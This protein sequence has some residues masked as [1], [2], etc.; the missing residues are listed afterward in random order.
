[1]LAA[2]PHR[3]QEMSETQKAHQGQFRQ[4]IGYSKGARETQEY[5]E[6]AASRGLR[7]ITSPWLTS[8]IRQSEVVE[9]VADAADVAAHVADEVETAQVV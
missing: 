1:M 9:I 3:S 7:R 4:A 6:A 2:A 8:C 5:G